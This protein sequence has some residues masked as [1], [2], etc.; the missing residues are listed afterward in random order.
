MKFGN[1]INVKE[2]LSKYT[3]TPP[4]P[5]SGYVSLYFKEDDKLY[6]KTSGGTE[7]EIGGGGGGTL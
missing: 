1:I 5:A 7:T 6:K 2:S 3:A 4:N